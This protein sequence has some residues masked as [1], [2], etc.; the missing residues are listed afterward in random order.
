VLQTAAAMDHFAAADRLLREEFGLAATRYDGAELTALEPALKPGLAGGWH[1]ATDGHLRP[2]RLLASWR[3]V[4]EARGVTIH[5]HCPMTGL[6]TAGRRATAVETPRGLL[7]ADAFVIA[8][9]AW[10]PLL[11]GVIGCRVP[12]QPGKG[13]SITMPRLAI[14]PALPLLF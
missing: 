1:Y 3:R 10:T 8:T 7:P 11:E 14:C 4:L 12:I 5:E 9:G 13:Y 2:D 6:A